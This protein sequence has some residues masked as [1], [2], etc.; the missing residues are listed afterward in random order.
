MKLFHSLRAA[1]LCAATVGAAT[2]C[3]ALVTLSPAMAVP[4]SGVKPAIA[5]SAVGG[6]RRPGP[7]FNTA[8]TGSSPSVAK[9]RPMATPAPSKPSDWLIGWKR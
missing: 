8:S 7:I 9:G 6:P 4:I 1:T 5:T 3:G 2:V